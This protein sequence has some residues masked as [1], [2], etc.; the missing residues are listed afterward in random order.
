MVTTEESILFRGVGSPINSDMSQQEALEAT[1]LNW[2]TC[3]KEFEYDFDGERLSSLQANTLAAIRSDN[4]HLLTVTGTNWQPYQNSQLMSDFY[5]FCDRTGLIPDWGGFICRKHHSKSHL[6]PNMAFVSAKIPES[7]GGVFH[8]SPDEVINSRL[9]FFNHHTYGY[10]AGG[11]LLTCRQ[12]CSNGMTITVKEARNLISHIRSQV[13][14]HEKIMECLSMVRCQFTKYSQDLELLADTLLTPEEALAILIKDFGKPGIP[15]SDQP[16]IVK[17]CL[18]LFLGHFDEQMNE[19][20]VNLGSSTLAAF[21][22]AYGLLQ[23]VTAYKNHLSG[24]VAGG[25]RVLSML[26]GSTAETTTKIHNTL[27]KVARSPKTVTL[28]VPVREL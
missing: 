12:I 21:R 11:Y 2:E 1:G 27:V 19:Q 8:L 10:G 13:G 18:E 7:M 5:T 15:L 14:S 22:T 28:S 20:G 6:A 23:S 26:S 17:T 25:G 9:V 4:G 3:L 16:K 24:A